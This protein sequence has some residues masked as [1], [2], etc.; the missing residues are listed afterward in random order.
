MLK[1]FDTAS[2]SSRLSVKLSTEH[3]KA[4]KRTSHMSGVIFYLVLVIYHLSELKCGSN[5][6]IQVTTP[7]I[8]VLQYFSAERDLF[9][10]QRTPKTFAVSVI[11]IM[12]SLTCITLLLHILGETKDRIFWR[13]YEWL[14]GANRRTKDVLDTA[15][16]ATPQVYNEKDEE[17]MKK[18]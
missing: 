17:F 2:D 9:A 14:G 16:T 4:A 5:E 12:V 6:S 1:I 11:V 13:I 7:C 10:F 15:S 8:L 3:M 18:F